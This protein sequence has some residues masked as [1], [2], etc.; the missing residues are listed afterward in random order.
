MPHCI[1]TCISLLACLSLHVY[2]YLSNPPVWTTSPLFR[3]GQQGIITK[4]TGNNETPTYNFSFSSPLPGVPSLGYGICR[5]E[6]NDYL[7][8]EAF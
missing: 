5:Y 6:G 3:A 7:G 2:S 8:I 1:I 4:Y